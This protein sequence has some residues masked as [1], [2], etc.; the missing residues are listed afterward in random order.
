MYAVANVVFASLSCLVLALRMC[1]RDGNIS[2]R[3]FDYVVARQGSR[4]LR[5]PPPTGE[6]RGS[7]DLNTYHH[8]VPP[9]LLECFPFS[10][11]FLSET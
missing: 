10:Q 3:S 11:I 4:D 5:S 1:F 7:V 8:N 9:V 6:L 2:Y